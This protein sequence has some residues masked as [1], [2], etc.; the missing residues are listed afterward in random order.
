[1]GHLPKNIFYLFLVKTIINR[2]IIEF[3]LEEKSVLILNLIVMS[4]QGNFFT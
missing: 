2:T 3:P 4:F 1:M